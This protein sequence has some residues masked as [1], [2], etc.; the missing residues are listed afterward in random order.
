VSREYMALWEEIDIVR[1]SAEL[2]A[3]HAGPQGAQK[4][5]T[6][7]VAKVVEFDPATAPYDGEWV[8]FEDGFRL[9]VPVDWRA[10]E[11]TEVES[12]A[13]LFYRAGDETSAAAVSYLSAGGLQT[14]DALAGDLERSGF[15]GIERL[16]LNGIEA[17]GFERPSDD[18]RGVA[19]FHPSVP[20]YILLIYVSPLG[21][22]GS[23]AE[24]R[25][26]ALLDSVSP[27]SVS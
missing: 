13:G 18:Y 4:A 16:Q 27:F 17:V 12:A 22:A 11:I 26:M 7:K 8:P 14:L 20:G 19:F 23:E 3:F 21:E 2:L 24:A 6:H 15:S 10:Y 25:G 1:Q 9:Y 5:G